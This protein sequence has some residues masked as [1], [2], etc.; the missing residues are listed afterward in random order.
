MENEGVGS[1]KDACGSAGQLAGHQGGFPLGQVL[2]GG[3]VV[4]CD[5]RLLRCSCWQLLV[6]DLRF[7]HVV[8]ARV[9]VF[10]LQRKKIQEWIILRRNN[11]KH[12][13]TTGTMG[14]INY[15]V[16]SAHCKIICTFGNLS[17]LF[18]SFL[19]YNFQHLPQK[20]R[21]F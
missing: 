3:D 8:I 16:L 7:S 13:R 11:G 14:P 12:F 20:T 6:L 10:L 21:W 9:K 1:R 2:G 17:I 19:N 15:N 4:P 18:V 5:L